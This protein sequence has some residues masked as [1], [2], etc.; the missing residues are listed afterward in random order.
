MAF[1]A[2]YGKY[3]PRQVWDGSEYGGVQPTMNTVQPKG[4]DALTAGEKLRLGYLV[5][6]LSD[7]MQVE[8]LVSLEERRQMLGL[9]PAG[10]SRP[11]WLAQTG[12]TPQAE[13]QGAQYP[14]DL[15]AE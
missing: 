12:R 4:E 13:I 3:T 14:D 9:K 10:D 8:P 6:D 2:N 7:P 11:T 15:V 1:D 5:G